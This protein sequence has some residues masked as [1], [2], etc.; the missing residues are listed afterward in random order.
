MLSKVIEKKP[1]VLIAIWL[2][3]VVLSAPLASSINNVVITN[4]EKLVPKNIESI[5]AMDELDN[6]RISNTSGGADYLILVQNVPVSLN[7]F[8]KLYLWYENFKKEH[9]NVNMTSWIDVVESVKEEISNF[10]KLGLEQ[11]YN[12]TNSTVLLIKNYNRTLQSIDGLSS[13]II[14]ADKA[15]AGTYKAGSAL[16]PTVPNL[17][18]VLRA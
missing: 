8:N 3:I 14:A 6:L 4:V 1:W 10:T 16:A 15:Y 18:G 13:L 2:I 12:A 11:F 7:T 17:L 5:R 9:N